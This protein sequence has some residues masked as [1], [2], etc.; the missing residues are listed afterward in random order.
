MTGPDV[1]TTEPAQMPKH[2]FFHGL[3]TGTGSF[4]IIAKRKMFFYIAAALI[5]IS[6]L[7]IGI[8]GFTFGIDFAG[9]TRVEMPAGQVS[10]S[11]AEEVFTDTLGIS[12]TVVQVVGTGA[13][14]SIQIRSESLDE[15]QI[16]EVQRALFNAF[17]PVDQAGEPNINA[18]SIAKV[19]ETW[20]GQVTQK[21][22]LALVVF[23]VL[24][25]VYISLRFEWHM[26][27]AAI[28]AVIL[29]LT[30]TAGVYALVGF[31]VSPATI[32]GLLTIL[33]Y[34]LYD[35]VVVFDKVQENTTGVTHTLRRTYAE[36][37]NLGVNQTLMRSFNT[38]L[39]SVLPIASLMIVAVWMLGVGTLKDLALVQLVGI[40]IGTYSSIFFATPLLVA[41][42]ER[43][44]AI[45]THTQNVLDRREV[46]TASVGVTTAAG[47][48]AASPAESER[49][50]VPSQRRGTAPSPGARPTGKR[51]R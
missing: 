26:A 17:Q 29:D 11:E 23:L 48:A 12:P 16:Q 4:Q 31:E 49:R 5:I 50:V 15:P 46:A 6:L 24:V 35:T 14:A 9:G 34:S 40:A 41:I 37:A 19:S 43:T 8:R 18:I 45:A 27:L 28:A 2:G 21:A 25:C 36:Q 38:S 44:E 20:G 33:G 47:V 42:K 7:G 3:Y 39:I 13:T 1:T 22:V 51:R 30:V 10:V 32:I